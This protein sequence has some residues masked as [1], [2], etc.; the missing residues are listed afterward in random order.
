MSA[1]LVAVLVFVALAPEPSLG[2]SRGQAHRAGSGLEGLARAVAGRTRRM[3]RRGRSAES[4]ARSLEMISRALRAGGS[5][6]TAL[7]AAAAEVPDAELT[8]V[9]NQMQSGRSIA[10]SLE[11]WAVGDPARQMAAALL[12][13]GH[14]SGASMAADLDR[15]AASL[16]R[17]KAL[18]DEIRALTA[19]TRASGVV[20]AVAPAGF[21]ALVALVDR[22]V[23]RVLFTTGI[24]WAALL[25]GITLEALGLWWMARLSKGVE[26]WA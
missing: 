15:A 6:R 18:S 22:D 11:R 10:G 19:Q 2:R 13:L 23:L 5:L 17:R 21:G 3:R 8:P 14:D 16:H 26:S 9:V 1:L 20:V 12:V 25:V 4:V 7:G 24:G